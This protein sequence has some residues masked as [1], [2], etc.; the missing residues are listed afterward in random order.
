MRKTKQKK[1]FRAGFVL[2][3]TLVCSCAGIRSERAAPPIVSLTQAVEQLGRD[4]FGGI[5][6]QGEKGRMVAVDLFTN[7]ESGEVPMAARRV[8]ALLL[9]EGRRRPG[10]VEPVGLSEDGQPEIRYLVTGTVASESEEHQG[11]PAYRLR[12]AVTDLKTGRVV[13]RSTARFADAGFDFSSMALYRDNPFFDPSYQKKKMPDERPR[14]ATPPPAE[15]SVQTLALLREASSAYERKAYK[16]S[17]GLFEK[18]ADRPDGQTLWTYAG[19]YL[20]Y[21]NLD[22][23]QSADEAFEK[24]LSISVARYG[25]LT[26][27]FLFQVD[28][29]DFWK[30]GENGKRY[31]SWL[32]RIGKYF[33]QTDQ[34]LQVVGHCS[35]TGPETWNKSLSLRRAE[36]I[37]Q[38]LGES[39]PGLLARVEAVGKGSA[40]NVV[41]IGTDDA[42]DALDRRVEL[43]VVGCR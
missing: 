4:L 13:V 32:R 38:I 21:E 37:Q 3:L 28:S 19:L 29:V 1:V 11:M 18:A 5:P 14:R 35:K 40:E 33:A 12:G 42:R 36:K 23:T 8:E 24:I 25:M 31:R 6:E 26:V 7:E 30:P 17:L 41:G 39:T 34:C 9:Q 20:V 2:C 22:R 15:Y 27:R 43:L 16:Q 10:T